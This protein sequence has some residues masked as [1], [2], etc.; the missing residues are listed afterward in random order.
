MAKLFVH[1][2][3]SLSSASLNVLFDKTFC[4]LRLFLSASHLEPPA[5][6]TKVS[7]MKRRTGSTQTGAVG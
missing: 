1:V 7:L 5:A 6:E 3:P 4:L 2:P